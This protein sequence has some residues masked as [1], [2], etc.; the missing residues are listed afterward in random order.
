MS[1]KYRRPR[2]KSKKVSKSSHQGCRKS[3]NQQ[4]LEVQLHVSYE[5][6]VALLRDELHSFGVEVG[7]MLSEKLLEE[8]VTR[9]CG[10]R[11]PAVE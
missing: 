10:N 5:D 9:L 3:N 7:L 8:E 2:S 1:R 6:L 11:H 4:N